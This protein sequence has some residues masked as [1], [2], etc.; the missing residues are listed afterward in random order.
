MM[1]KSEAI[2]ADVVRVPTATADQLHGADG[3]YVD[4]NAQGRISQGCYP[5]RLQTIIVVSAAPTKVR[6]GFRSRDG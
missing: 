1:I 4:L 5:K 3:P 2:G 6:I